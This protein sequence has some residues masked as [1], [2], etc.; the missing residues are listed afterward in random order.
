MAEEEHAEIS[1]YFRQLFSLHPHD[2]E[3]LPRLDPLILTEGEILSSLGKLGKG[4]ACFQH[5]QEMEVDASLGKR[6]A[7]T[8][9]ANRAEQEGEP[10]PKHSRPQSKGQGG[11]GKG[12]R[13]TAQ[14]AAAPSSPGTAARNPKTPEN[15]H[16][17]HPTKQQ[18]RQQ[19]GWKN[20]QGQRRGW[21]SYTW[22]GQRKQKEEQAW[23]DNLRLLARLC[24][25]HEDELSQTRVE[26]D[27]ILT[28]ETQEAAVLTKLY[29]LATVWK[30]RKER[31]EVDCSLRICLFLGLLQVWLERMRAL[32]QT[33][34]EAEALRKRIMEQ[35]YA[36]MPEGTTELQWFYMRWN[37][38]TQAMEKVPDVEPMLQSQVVSSLIQLQ[39]TMVAPN[40]LLRFHSTRRMA[41]EYA[42][43][44]VTF[45][46]TVGQRDTMAAQAWGMLTNLCGNGSGK[47]IGLK[48]KPAKMDRQPL[49]KIVAERF[50]PPFSSSRAAGSQNRE[51][52]AEDQQQREKEEHN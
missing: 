20:N 27:F 39:A 10:Q 34:P 13:G 29:K 6:E 49:A 51:A 47:V 8:V 1:A 16:Q 9:T 30:E 42:G 3:P 43:E 37:H 17:G 44:T 35:G 19:Q 15:R 7:P 11:Q 12:G 38:P 24:L 26:R 22:G 40:A 32:E 2:I 52:E 23:E 33:S 36:Q 4:K 14:E 50:P 45:L 18:G 48:M 28:M 41:A 25:R 5:M 21:S 31:Q 46:L